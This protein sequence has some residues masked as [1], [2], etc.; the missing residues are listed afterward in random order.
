MIARIWLGPMC[1]VKHQ[2]DPEGRDTVQD[3]QIEGVAG[4]FAGASDVPLPAPRLQGE[5][6]PRPRP[7]A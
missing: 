5:R 1:T 7:P 6:E 3:R 2:T 4:G